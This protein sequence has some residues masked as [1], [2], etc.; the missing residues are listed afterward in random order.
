MASRR[1][2]YQEDAKLRIMQII[3]SNPQI[4]SRQIAK[5][6][7]ISNGSAYY[8]ITSLIDKGFIKLINFKE[9]SEKIK[10]SYL[11]TPKGVRQK[12]LLTGKFLVRKRKEYIALKEEINSFEQCLGIDSNNEK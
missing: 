2:E 10:Y 3:V 5:K 12:S 11:L 9:S 7:R 6:I 4:T 8:L 1:E